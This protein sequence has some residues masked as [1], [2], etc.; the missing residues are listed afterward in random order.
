VELH[1]LD[2][3]P[4]G[5]GDPSS[6]DFDNRTLAAA[7]G[8]VVEVR[9]PWALLGYADPS[10]VTL[11]EAHPDGRVTTLTAG[12]VGIAVLSDGSSLLSTTGYAWGPWQSVT[13][14]ERKKAGFDELANTMRQLSA[15]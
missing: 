8:I 4:I 15:L 6:S 11:Y 12:R 1:E 13:W 2:N 14:H 5:N 9:L 7:Q 3:L 10:S